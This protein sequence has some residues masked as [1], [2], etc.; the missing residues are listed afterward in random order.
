MLRVLLLLPL[1]TVTF[2]GVAR[3]ADGG[4]DGPIGPGCGA[5]TIKGCCEGSVLRYCQSGVLRSEDCS[6]KPSC[7]WRAELN[8][9]ACDSSG[10]SDPSGKYAKVCPAANAD[11]GVDQGKPPTPDTGPVAD[12]AS[13]VDGG[14]ADAFIWQMPD[15][16]TPTP[17]DA[18]ADARKPQATSDPGCG[19]RSGGSGAATS[20]GPAL[21]LLVA[22]WHRRRERRRLSA[23][24]G[25]GQPQ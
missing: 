1:L 25:V 21:L 18:T 12:G 13:T 2:A 11:A 22:L 9:Y 19:C 24:R 20:S 8:Y 14:S 4:S 10:G 3:A 15:S 6:A 23:G 7:G 16:G 5:V 17:R